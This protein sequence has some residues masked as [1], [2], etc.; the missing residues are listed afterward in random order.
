[1]RPTPRRYAKLAPIPLAVAMLCGMGVQTI[2]HPSG[3]DA[4]PF[5]VRAAEEIDRVS[6]FI[7]PW[8]GADVPVPHEAVALLR[9]N[10]ILSRVYDNTS[11]GR[12][13]HLLVV[14]CRDARDMAG[15]YPP[16]CYRAN[17]MST[18]SAEQRD[19]DIGGVSIPGM[20]YHFRMEM[21]GQSVDIHVD[22]FLILPG[23]GFVRDMRPVY[24]AAANRMR[25]FY[26]AAQVQVKVDGPAAEEERDEIFRTLVGAALPA[27]EF[28]RAGADQ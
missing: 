6:R 12:R 2:S 27:I 5:H 19:W 11:T 16:V 20:R 9:P 10:K 26:G 23:Q 15:H 28:I 8:T 14:Q 17:G 21:P 7:G 22:N 13:A 18:V 24:R 1:M 4:E 25:H 3:E